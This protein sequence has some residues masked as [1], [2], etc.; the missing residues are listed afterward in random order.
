VETRN[1]EPVAAAQI[2]VNGDMPDHG[3]GLPTRPEVL[4]EPEAGSY[5]VEGMK[6][7]MPGWWVV[8]FSIKTADT[9][10]SVIFNLMLQ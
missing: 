5:L 9:E 4:K 6:F 8:S 7:N 10:D 3:H 2:T 1:G